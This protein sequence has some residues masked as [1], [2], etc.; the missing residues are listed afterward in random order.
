[1]SNPSRDPAN[2]QEFPFADDDLRR[3]RDELQERLQRTQAEFLNYQKRAK[4]QADAE[5]PYA[6]A[7]LARDLLPVLDNLERAIDAARAAGGST[8]VDG[9]AMVHKQLIDALAKHG[10]AAISALHQPFDPGFHEAIRQEPSREH[11]EGTVVVEY[12]KGYKHHDRVLR[13]SQVAVA[14]PAE[15]GK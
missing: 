6:S 8:I 3:E 4:A 15:P 11:P 2:D 5:R 12:A 10:V 9:V 1:M 13:P 14:V 7:G